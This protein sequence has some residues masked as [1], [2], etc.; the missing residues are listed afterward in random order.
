MVEK[1]EL[2]TVRIIAISVK[3]YDTH[4]MSC[5]ST[6]NDT[7]DRITKLDFSQ[8]EHTFK[9]NCVTCH[10]IVNNNVVEI[11][12]LEVI[13]GLRGNGIGTQFM[14]VFTHQCPYPITLQILYH[15]PFNFYSRLGF[16]IE[17]VAALDDNNLITDAT[18]TYERGV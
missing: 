2:T 7:N 17:S 10:Y 6:L 18:L 4:D 14:K 9:N 3:G 11:K 8:G 15:R 5:V 12:N 13:S 16:Q 1:S